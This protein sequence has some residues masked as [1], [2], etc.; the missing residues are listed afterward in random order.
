[1]FQLNENKIQYAK[2]WY[3]NIQIVLRRQFIALGAYI[4]KE[5]KISNRYSRFLPQ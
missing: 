4:A 2:M 1:M 5:K 3:Y